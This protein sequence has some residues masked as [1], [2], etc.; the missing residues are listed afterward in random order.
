MP[1]KFHSLL[2]ERGHFDEVQRNCKYV[3]KEGKWSK[4]KKLFKAALEKFD[5]FSRQPIFDWA[6][7]VDNR[8]SCYWAWLKIA[9]QECMP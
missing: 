4:E 6:K 7:N 9:E 8:T 2:Y 1:F 3:V 5:K